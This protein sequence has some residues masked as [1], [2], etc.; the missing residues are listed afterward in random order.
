MGVV[1]GGAW[2]ELSWGQA[3]WGVYQG[4]SS[5]RMRLGRARVARQMPGEQLRVEWILV[6]RWPATG[7]GGVEPQYT[8]KTIEL[9]VIA[10]PW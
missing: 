1:A 8:I 6:Q 7:S 5:T 4:R 3:R 10:P 2:I 9:G